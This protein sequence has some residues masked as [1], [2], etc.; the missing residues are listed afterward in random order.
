MRPR[1]CLVVPK[2]SR[3]NDE[4]GEVTEIEVLKALGFGLTEA[5]VQAVETWRFEPARLDARPIPVRY[6]LTVRFSLR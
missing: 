3:G 6:N 2:R 4:S 5:A 1:P